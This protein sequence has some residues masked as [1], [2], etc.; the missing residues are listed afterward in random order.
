M[1]VEGGLRRGWSR[2]IKIQS[3]I[4]GEEE[5][6][7]VGGEKA[8]TVVDFGGKQSSEG[9]GK[10]LKEAKQLLAVSLFAK[11]SGTWQNNT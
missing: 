9:E 6:E 5:E 11:I 7:E 3:E 4:S 10:R 8:G 1:I 2:L